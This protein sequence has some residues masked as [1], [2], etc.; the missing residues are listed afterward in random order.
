M[1]G[2]R[3]GGGGGGGGGG[4]GIG[5]LNG[6]I[7]RELG[8]EIRARGCCPVLKLTTPFLFSLVPVRLFFP[9]GV[10]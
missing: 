9:R 3:G 6:G 1:G 4:I 2:G 5:G 10:F 8:L 7:R